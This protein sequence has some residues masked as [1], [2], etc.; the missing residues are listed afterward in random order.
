MTPPASATSS[1]SPRL[2]DETAALLRE[3]YD[4]LPDRGLRRGRRWFETR[5]MLR[6]AVALAGGDAPEALYAPDRFTRVGALPPT[7]LRLLQGPD[8][9]NQLD[10]AAHRRRK[11]AFLQLLDAAA[12][13]AVT[14]RFVGAW[15]RRM[16]PG[17][18]VVLL[19]EAERLLCEAALDWVGA[20]ARSADALA[21][22]T[23]EFAAMVGAAGSA[24]P[25]VAGA[26]VL[27][28]RSERWARRAIRAARANG[29]GPGTPLA[30]V[31]A[32][33]DED[34]RLLDERVAAIELIN[35]LRPTVAVARYVVFAADALGRLPRWRARLRDGDAAT[36]E[37]F[38]QE[39]RRVYPF[40]PAAAGRVLTPF[41]W[42]GRR[43][44]RGEWVMADLHGANHDPARWDQPEQFDPERFLADPG[45]GARVAAQ[46][47]GDPRTGHR[48]PGEGLTV[49]LIGAAARELAVMDYAV[50]PQDL[51]IDL[52]RMPA[53]PASGYVIEM[54][55]PAV[56]R[57]PRPAP[58][59]YGAGVRAGAL[60]L[61]GAFAGLGVIFL[62]TPRAASRLFGLPRDDPASLPYVRAL[63]FRDLGLAAAMGLTALRGRGLRSLAAG[64]ALI[65]A[66]DAAL[67]ARRRGRAAAPSAALHL[68][69]AAALLALV[70]A[71]PSRAVARRRVQAGFQTFSGVRR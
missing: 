18:R 1:A 27:R 51:S 29:A 13:E 70:G 21:R 41:E 47:A 66:L 9:V 33:T 37:A 16:R 71:R 25:D 59:Q 50:P 58:P 22:R 4:F 49:A 60:A 55:D 24:G 61:A 52:S 5:L 28:R 14:H 56:V 63:G 65:P 2:A 67:V 38:A 36:R 62:G 19:H 10:G 20:P 32:W 30:R 54:G 11:A 68:V 17:R 15:R 45:L 46:G 43:F 48:C 42:E 8:S 31:A 3:G 34:G 39:V 23:R 7:T 26:L 64:A 40:F 57:L 69:S 6:R 12:V 35:L 53:A 44:R